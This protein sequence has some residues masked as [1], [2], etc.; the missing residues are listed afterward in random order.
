M[1]TRAGPPAPRRSGASRA[2]VVVCC[3]AL[4]VLLVVSVALSNALSSW[5]WI[6]TF[7]LAAAVWLVLRRR[8]RAVAELS[9]HHLDERDLATRGRAAWWG[10]LTATS[11]G[12]L[13]SVAL[14]IA[15]RLDAVDA[16]T[17]VERS[18]PVLVTLMFTASLVP[19]LVLAATTD[20]DAETEDEDFH[21][22]AR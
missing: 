15:A 7:L 4:A 11:A 1:P 16:Q 3:A 22:S 17:I 8:T 20:P 6:A 13:L 2:L 5:V 9:A 18:G 12:T 21:G 14:V 10:L 19:T